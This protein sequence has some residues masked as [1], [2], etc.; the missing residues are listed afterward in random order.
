MNV[1]G[2]S[3]R[4][5]RYEWQESRS[6]VPASDVTAGRRVFPSRRTRAVGIGVSHGRRLLCV[7][8]CG[9]SSRQSDV[10][11]VTLW[12]DTSETANCRY[13]IAESLYRSLMLHKAAATGLFLS[14]SPAPSAPRSQPREA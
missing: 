9:R 3:Q 13:Y 7:I 10:F 6:P 4:F 8:C 1:S 2:L 12:R 11:L 14:V 5:S